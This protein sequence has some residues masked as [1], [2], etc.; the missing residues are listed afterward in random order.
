MRA[1]T[2]AILPSRIAT[3]RTALILFLASMTCPPC[4]NRSY[5]VWARQQDAAVTKNAIRLRLLIDFQ[6]CNLAPSWM[7]RVPGAV[8]FKDVM[9][10]ND[11]VLMVADGLPKFVWLNRANVSKRS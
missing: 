5:C 10:P 4:S 1:S 6:N 3:S 7:L 11:D 2:A 9:L 8:E